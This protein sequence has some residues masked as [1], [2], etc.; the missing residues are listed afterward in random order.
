MNKDED[1]TFLIL[2]IV[3]VGLLFLNKYMWAVIDLAIVKSIV[4]AH[5]GKI[6]VDSML[7]KESNFKV[8]LPLK[9]VSHGG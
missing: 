2:V 5:N 6:E 9:Y 3:L 7:G 8:Y 1:N 4:K